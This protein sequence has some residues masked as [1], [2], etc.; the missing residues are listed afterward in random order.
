MKK[1][2]K[3]LT[4]ILILIP[5]IF[6]N[7]QAR[8]IYV[9]K[10]RGSNINDGSE[11]TPYRTIQKG[12]DNASAGDTVI[13]KKAVYYESVHIKNKGTAENPIIIKAEEGTV[14]SGADEPLRKNI[15]KNLFALL[16]I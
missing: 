2:I 14:V 13:V 10:M 4:F 5:A 16:Y 6:I 9:D 12:V 11:S 7:V 15:N 3:I 8:T 1:I